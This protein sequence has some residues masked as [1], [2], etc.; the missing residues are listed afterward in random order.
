M[1]NING[2]VPNSLESD[3]IS[4][5]GFGLC[6]DQWTFA[7][8]KPVPLTTTADGETPAPAQQTTIAGKEKTPANFRPQ[9]ATAPAQ[10]T[11][12]AG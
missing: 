5:F 11:S 12:T 3:D 2:K 9:T 6:G 4:V 7:G 10:Q 1:T 8:R